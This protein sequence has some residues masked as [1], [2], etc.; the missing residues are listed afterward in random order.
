MNYI[1]EYQLASCLIDIVKKK[2]D[3][4]PKINHWIVKKIFDAMFDDAVYIRTMEQKL[5]ITTDINKR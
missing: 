4:Y 5:N 2:I 1:D 3:N